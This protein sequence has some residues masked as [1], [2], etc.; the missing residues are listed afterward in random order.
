[1]VLSESQLNHIKA[2]RERTGNVNS[3]DPF[4]I[5]FYGLLRDFVQPGD[6]EKLVQGIIDH[7]GQECQ[8]TNGFWRTMPRTLYGD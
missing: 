2:M 8:F 1:M 6:L 3:V 4:V 7:T 5:I